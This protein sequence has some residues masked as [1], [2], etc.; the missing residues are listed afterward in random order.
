MSDTLQRHLA[1]LSHIPAL[2]GKVAARDLHARLRDEG[3]DVDVRSVERDL[4]KLS[5]CFPLVN[6]EARPAGWSWRL[7]QNPVRF[8]RMDASTAL[9]YE[10]IARYLTPA[11]PRTLMKRLE[12]ELLQARRTLDDYPSTPLSRWSRRITVLPLGHQLLPPEIR[13]DVSEV[14]YDALLGGHRFEADYRAVGNTEPKRHTIN[15]LG[16]VYRTGVLYLVATLRDYDN[17]LH[18]ALHRMSKVQASEAPATIPKGFD[19][20]RYVREEKSFDYPCGADIRLEVRVEAWLANHLE[21]S[22][23]SEDQVVEPLRDGE[24]FRVSATVPETDQLL[25]WLRSFGSSLEV[26]K[27][28]RLRKKM[29]DDVRKLAMTYRVSAPAKGG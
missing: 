24:R 10:L 26:V 11:L 5:E 14:V 4:H 29:A 27:P 18:L 7:G 20:E 1:L 25:W 6:D 21:E 17:P 8:P 13:R 2:P 3:Y 22:R 23:L 15:P 28:V 9:T 19:F 16:L 12:P